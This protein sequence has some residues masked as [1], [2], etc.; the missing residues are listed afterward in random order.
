M[1]RLLAGCCWAVR[2]CAV[3]QEWAVMGSLGQSGL[4]IIFLSNSAVPHK[5]EIAGLF[6]FVVYKFVQ[7]KFDFVF[8]LN[9]HMAQI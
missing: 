8:F 3:R 2:G 7:Q 9:R 5:E 6:L 1:D 4:I